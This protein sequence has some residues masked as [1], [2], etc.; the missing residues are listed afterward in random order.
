MA[1]G[2]GPPGLGSVAVT[3]LFWLVF[4]LTAPVCVV[5]GVALFLLS[6][7]FDREGHLLHAFVCRW[8]FSYLRLNPLWQ[9]RV[10]GREL[11]PAGPAVLVANHQSMVDVV[12]V[13]GLFHPY[14]FVSKESLF[15]LPLVG[16]MMRLI[17]HV[18]LRRGR[19]HAT[20][21]MLEACRAWLR[22]G[23]AVLFFPEGTYSSGP[24]MLPFR[25]GAFLLAMEEAVPLVPIL[26]EGTRGL[27]VGDGPWMAP[28][29]VLRVTVLP[30]LRPPHPTSA[31][32]FAAAVQALY[33]A[34]LGQ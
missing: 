15:G 13:M 6:W 2:G 32:A 18:P 11:L 28:R 1:K 17:R 25:P 31:G 8:T 3:A 22:R 21:E 30:A 7:P 27:V 24:E 33:R 4:A 5:L 34:R 20:R 10:E 14:K 26:L 16:W 12:A 23:T 29:A 9:V 19:P